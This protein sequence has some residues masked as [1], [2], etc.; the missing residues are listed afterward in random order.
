M[1]EIGDGGEDG[2]LALE[3]LLPVV[4]EGVHI[5]DAAENVFPSVAG[6]GMLHEW[7][8]DQTENTTSGVGDEVTVS[9]RL[10]KFGTKLADTGA[11][12]TDNVGIVIEVDVE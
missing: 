12:G 1:R 9:T 6:A 11:D 5:V 3:F 10:G 8:D 4:R 2:D 7:G